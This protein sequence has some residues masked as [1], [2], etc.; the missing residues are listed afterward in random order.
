MLFSLVD[1]QQKKGP[2]LMYA[3]AIATVLEFCSSATLSLFFF[4]EET[5]SA[6]G[7]LK[8]GRGEVGA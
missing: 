6:R 8:R 3:I 7:K 2:T 1:I 5:D 4:L